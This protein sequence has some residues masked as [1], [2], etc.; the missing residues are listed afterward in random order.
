MTTK[1]P[2]KEAKINSKILIK[3]KRANNGKPSAEGK[4]YWELRIDR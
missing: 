2:E 4:M 3:G 1:R